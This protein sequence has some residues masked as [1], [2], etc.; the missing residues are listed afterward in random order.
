MAIIDQASDLA[1]IRGLV[2]LSL[3]TTELPDAVIQRDVYL[4]A[5]EASI[6]GQ[7]KLTEAAFKAQPASQQA[8][9]KRAMKYKAA[10]LIIPGI[11]RLVSQTT[12]DRLVRLEEKDWTLIIQEYNAIITFNAPPASDTPR[13]SGVIG[14][15]V[16]QTSSRVD[17]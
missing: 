4:G 14:I 13:L 7:L 10:T 6:L 11:D 5:A 15:N 1:E 3:T 17:S 9:G 12:L 8:P 16:A 2:S